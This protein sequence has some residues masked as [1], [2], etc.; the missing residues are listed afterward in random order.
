MFK[1]K[2]TFQLKLNS[3]EPSLFILQ[4]V[5]V[6]INDST[7]YYFIGKIIFINFKCLTFIL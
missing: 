2:L 7:L 5:F 3:P 4:N 1:K 6:I